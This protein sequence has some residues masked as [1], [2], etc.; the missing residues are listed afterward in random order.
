MGSIKEIVMR[1]VHIL[2]LTLLTFQAIKAWTPG[3]SQPHIV[4][5][6]ADDLGYNDVSWNNGD[7]IS[8]NMQ[9]MVDSG[10][11]LNQFYTQPTCSPSRAALL[12]GQYPIHT[13][14]NEGVLTWSTKAGLETKFP[15]IAEELKDVG[16]AT[17]MLGK[18]HVGWC[19]SSY[20]PQNRGFDSFRGIWHGGTDRYNYITESDPQAYDLHY[21]NDTDTENNGTYSSIL[22][23]N[24][25]ETIINDHDASEPLFLYVALQNVHTPLEAPT[26][27]LSQ[28]NSYGLTYK[29]KKASA[30]VTAIDEVI[31]QIKE[32]LD[33]NG[34]LDNSII[35]FAS[36]NG[37]LPGQGANNLPLRGGKNSW[38]EGGVKTPAFI[39]SPLFDGSLTAGSDNECMFHVTDWF[40]TMLGFAGGNIDEL[41]VDGVDQWD[42]LVN[43]G[44]S[45]ARDT[46]LHN[47]ELN[48]RGNVNTATY[49][50]GDYKI[51]IGDPG[52][53]TG[54]Y[55]TTNT[56]TAGEDTTLYLFDIA[57]DP[58]EE[59]NL[60]EDSNYAT[61]LAD[62]EETVDLW[63]TEVYEF[64]TSGTCLE[65]EVLDSNGNW[66]T[67]CCNI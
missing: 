9:D 38:F 15:T 50:E 62:L 57:S 11:K 1:V 43:G 23:G 53:L 17:H 51:I 61:I 13:G 37:G 4:F 28:Y 21:N 55:D 44:S 3:D 16:Y 26:E 34:M 45:C 14:F 29:R 63:A 7:I 48:Y 65:S 31:L 18:W 20:L 42:T 46:I 33:S 67:G 40:T 2:L 36:D 12:T 25:A 64:A 56:E 59:T 5:V 66:I 24:A 10:I 6:F 39:Y 22:Y 47:I 27:Y 58:N 52:D 30:M 35:I 41:D 54:W 49:R 32:A 60:A 8:P 19:N